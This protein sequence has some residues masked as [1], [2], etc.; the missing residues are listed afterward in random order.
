MK[1]FKFSITIKRVKWQDGQRIIR[2]KV[3]AM[4][5]HEAR[6]IL[7]DHLLQM[8]YQVLRIDLVDELAV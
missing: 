7:L 3:R 5:E 2:D 6:R 4:N 8:G 1:T